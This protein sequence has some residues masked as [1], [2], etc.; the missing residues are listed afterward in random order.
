MVRPLRAISVPFGQRIWR[1]S[2]IGAVRPLTLAHRAQG[3]SMPTIM[4]R[5]DGDNRG[6]IRM[7]VTS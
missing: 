6:V 2:V 3:V 1:R 5:H 7:R 4:F